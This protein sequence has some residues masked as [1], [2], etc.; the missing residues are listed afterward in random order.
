MTETRCIAD[1]VKL[2]EPDLRKF[3]QSKFNLRRRDLTDE[4][5][6]RFYLK[7]IRCRSLEKWD[8]SRG[9][10][11]SYVI[12]ILCWS[13]KKVEQPNSTDEIEIADG[14]SIDELNVRE[15]IEDLAK[16]IRG[17]G[18]E[19]LVP[20]LLTVLKRAIWG[21]PLYTNLSWEI[22]SVYIGLVR[23][24]VAEEHRTLK[25]CPILCQ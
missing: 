14:R 21:E 10:Y 13:L 5:I 6:S 1:F 4:I 2:N 17:Y 22:P 15:R 3:L 24:F 20:Q 25:R 12:S 8:R 16:Y 18:P 9:T 7:L 23:D 19:S 11:D